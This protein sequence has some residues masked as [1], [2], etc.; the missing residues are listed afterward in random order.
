MS[1][2]EIKLQDIQQDKHVFDLFS[3]GAIALANS[4]TRINGLTIAWGSLGILWNK[5]TCVV[6]IHETRYSRLIFD[7]ADCFSVCFFDAAYDSQI[8]Y[9]GRV[10][11]RDIDKIK[12]SGLRVQE[13]NG[14]PYF[15]EAKLVILCRKMAQSQFD[16][17]KISEGKIKKWYEK[18]GV[19]TI[20]YG[21]IVKVFAK[22]NESDL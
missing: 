19:H 12:E 16:L 10:S 5:P 17:D 9:F 8:D 1:H 7:E 11:G 6:Y 18:D 13:D 2:K 4:G 21:E 20:Y 3:D 22:N 14:T 15:A